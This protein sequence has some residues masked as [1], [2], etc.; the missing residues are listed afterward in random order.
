MLF[1]EQP[2]ELQELYKQM[3][4]SAGAL[5]NLFS[6]NDA[7][8]IVSRNVENA[9]CEAFGAENLGRSD[10][11]ADASLNGV[12]IGVKTFI[13]GNGKTLQKV[14]EFNKDAVLYKNLQP[15]ELIYTVANLRNE[16]I[17]FTMRTYGLDS[18]I[19]HCVTRL[20][21]KIL[22]FE[23]TMDQIDIPNI[24]NIDVS[25]KNTITFDDGKN[26]YSF[27]L[28]KSTLYK[29]FF[30][31]DPLTEI[32]VSILEKPYVSLAKLFDTFQ[33]QSQFFTSK[34][35]MEQFDFFT[36]N[37][38]TANVIEPSSGSGSF[39]MEALQQYQIKSKRKFESRDFVILPLFSDRGNKR[40]V[41]EKSGLNQ[42]NA[43]G[44]PRHH[45]EVYIP[46]PKWIH[47]VFPSFFPPRDESFQLNLPDKS[48]LSAKV[49]Q[50]NSKALMTNPNRDLGEW[51]LRKVL[52]LAEREL[53]TFEKLEILGID[54]VNVY[55]HSDKHYSIDFCDI[56]TFD[57]FQAENQK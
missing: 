34:S 57:E 30:T 39:L 56:G 4:R 44:R 2:K 21:G 11:S 24:K 51:M 55:K 31:D 12:G 42:W 40:H 43:S 10:C 41:P 52:G 35:I 3:L 47:D 36:N 20:P 37:K 46:I 33:P 29:R 38:N 18:M 8:Y 19:Y 23:S 6:D 7:P 48:L 9:F 14:A 16:R 32:N 22:I 54:S 53:L 49:C 17:E 27:N 15:K 13:H 5:S 28:T 26:E 45:D 1:N 25:N 50:E